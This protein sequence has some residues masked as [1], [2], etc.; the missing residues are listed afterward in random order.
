MV[1]LILPQMILFAEI[2]RRFDAA[3]NL[4]YTR[5]WLPLVIWLA[6]SLLVGWKFPFSDPQYHS[7]IKILLLSHKLFGAL[8]LFALNAWLFL[9]YKSKEA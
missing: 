7:G 2:L 8:L 4:K 5:S 6:G 1:I 9:T 3:A